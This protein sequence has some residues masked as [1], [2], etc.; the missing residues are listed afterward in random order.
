MF[1]KVA[2][3]YNAEIACTR[4]LVENGIFPYERQVGQS[5]ISIAPKIYVAFGISGASQ[6]IIGIMNADMVIAINNDS[7]APIFEHSNYKVV[8]DVR[9]VLEN[10]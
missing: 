1:K 9:E 7:K 10:L 5:G 4:P 8:S 3:K 6:H 2:E